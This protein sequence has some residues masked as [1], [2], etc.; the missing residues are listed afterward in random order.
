M[1]PLFAWFTRK[2]KAVVLSLM[3]KS[4]NEDVFSLDWVE[5][6]GLSLRQT[7]VLGVE[8]AWNARMLELVEGGRAC[9]R[10]GHERKVKRRE[11]EPMVL[12]VL[13][14][15][16]KLAKV[17]LECDDCDAPGLSVTRLLTGLSSGDASGRVELMAGYC[18]AQG[19]YSTASRDLLVHHGLEV[20]RT[21]VRRMALEVEAEA[22]TF[23]E[24]ERKR[25]LVRLGEEGNHA[26]AELLMFQG[27]GGIVR[28]GVLKPCEPGDPG[29]GKTTPKREKPRRKREIDYH[30]IITLDVRQ[31]GTVEAQ[32]LDVVVPAV[33]PEGERARR[34]LALAGRA[35]LGDD[36]VMRGL[37]DMGSK[38]PESFDEAF[39]EHDSKYS[40]DWTHVKSYVHKASQALTVMDEAGREAWRKKMLDA[41]WKRNR[42]RY[43]DLLRQAKQH[44]PHCRDSLDDPPSGFEK[45]PVLAMETYCKNNWNRFWAREYKEAGL[46]FVSARAEAQVR[47]RT[48]KRY[49]IPGAWRT[50]NLEPKAVLRSIIADGRWDTFAVAYLQGR[51]AAASASRLARLQQ[52]VEEGRLSK[53][54]VGAWLPGRR[55][56]EER[57]MEAARAA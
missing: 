27:D 30:E 25:E 1:D 39:V 38:L 9:P 41:I 29:F 44:C 36:T 49:D 54:Q 50:E 46:D 26:G 13:G 10:C 22:V 4:S 28:T 45:C 2:V 51:K 15:E 7:L 47:E 11:G 19:S 31:P 56:Q 57:P 43:R 14:G 20:E 18:A 8:Q 23:A 17:Y 48:K 32:A 55:K 37:G 12:E 16:L 3:R 21:K 42:R 5:R 24:A 34:I 52:A 6:Q 53:A 35:G 33:A 40:A